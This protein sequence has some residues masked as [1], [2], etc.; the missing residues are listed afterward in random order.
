MLPQEIVYKKLFSEQ[1]S[2]SIINFLDVK[3]LE[4]QNIDWAPFVPTAHVLSIFLVL[5]TIAILTAVYYSKIKKLNPT[6]PPTGYVLVVQLLILQF[7]NLTVELL[8]EKNRKITPL[9]IVIFLYIT[10]SNLVS[11]VGGIAAPTSSSTVTFSL[12]LMSFLGSVIIGLKYQ[13]LAYF[14]EFF[15]NVKIKNKSIPVFPNPLNII[16]WVSPLLSISLRLWGNIL[17]G[18]IFIALL[19]SVFRTF[20]TLGSTDSF[21]VGLILGTIA[22]G[23]I[24]PFF[25]IY[26]DI[27]I[28]IIQ[29]FVFVSLMLTYW[30]QP[31]KN[32]EVKQAE[33]LERTKLNVK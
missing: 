24:V 22:G 29:A 14:S 28:A 25:H 8:G 10:V 11:L 7:E 2:Q 5:F 1:T 18:S 21:N 30:S 33:K 3:P 6:T 17:A 9:F 13:K 23:L 16:G 31:I 26:F 32:E 19:Y 20:F 4:S 15:V 27:L 12:G